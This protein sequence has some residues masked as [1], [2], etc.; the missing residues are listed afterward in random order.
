MAFSGSGLIRGVAISESGLIRGVAF[1]GSSLIRG[2]AFS[3]SGLIRGGAILLKK[4]SASA[5]WFLP[6][7]HTSIVTIL[8]NDCY[9]SG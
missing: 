7:L 5:K 9:W 3:G 2:V 1:S 6:L 4:T 8:M